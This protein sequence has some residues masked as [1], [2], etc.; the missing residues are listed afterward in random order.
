[1]STT[2]DQ[3]SQDPGVTGYAEALSELQRILGE[4]ES[5]SVDVDRLAALVN[6]ARTLIEFCRSRINTARLSIE[7]VI[8]DLD[9]EP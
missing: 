5:D 6:R 2:N 4:L 7:T 1:V 3:P 8:A 9:P